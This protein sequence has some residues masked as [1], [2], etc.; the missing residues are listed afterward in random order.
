MEQDGLDK[1]CVANLPGFDAD[2]AHRL[3]GH[4]LV[5]NGVKEG[6]LACRHLHGNQAAL[7]ALDAKITLDPPPR[8]LFRLTE[9]Q[10]FG[11]VQYGRF[12]L[13]MWSSHNRLHEI[14]PKPKL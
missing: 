2:D 10:Y 11:V 13:C 5:P 4:Y 14:S 7:F 1:R 6:L 3:A 12:P 9:F 8:F